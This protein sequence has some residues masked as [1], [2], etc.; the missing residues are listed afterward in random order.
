M[1]GRQLDMGKNDFFK[2]FIAQEWEFG[3]YGVE[4]QNNKMLSGFLIF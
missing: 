1:L 3:E 4:I 2:M